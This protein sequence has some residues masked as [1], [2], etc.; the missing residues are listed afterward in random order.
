MVHAGPDVRFN[1]Y[2]TYAGIRFI[3]ICM[4]VAPDR[5]RSTVT[6]SQSTGNRGDRLAEACIASGFHPMSPSMTGCRMFVSDQHWWKH[7]PLGR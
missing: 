3:V 4:T 5:N 2:V 6:W 7:T 1:V